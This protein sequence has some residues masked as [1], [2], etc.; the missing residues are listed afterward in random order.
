MLLKLATKLFSAWCLWNCRINLFFVHRL[1]CTST[2]VC[3]LCL[4]HWPCWTMILHPVRK[5]R[6]WP[7]SLCWKSW[8]CRIKIPC[9]TWL[10]AGLQ[11]R[12]WVGKQYVENYTS[13]FSFNSLCV[14]ALADDYAEAGSSGLWA[15][16]GS[17]RGKV[18]PETGCP[19]SSHRERDPHFQLRGCECRVLY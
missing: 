2:A 8:I 16:C 6:L 11:A 1:S 19:D 9:L 5:W 18:Q 14:C 12:R 17:S 10:T 3:S 7:S 4:C 15:V 13:G